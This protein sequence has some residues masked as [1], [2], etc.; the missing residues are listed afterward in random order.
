MTTWGGSDEDDKLEAEL[1]EALKAK[2]E[3]ERIAA[4]GKKITPPS[5]NGKRG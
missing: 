2:K 1:R 5:K 4:A 3:A